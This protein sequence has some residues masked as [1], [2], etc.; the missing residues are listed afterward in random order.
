MYSVNFEPQRSFF[1]CINPWLRDSYMEEIQVVL[2]GTPSSGSAS[3]NTC[4]QIDL[5]YLKPSLDK[6][7]RLL[8]SIVPSRTTL[9]N[10]LSS[11]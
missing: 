5:D 9:W 8:T 7:I 3:E 1:T 2:K 6:S 4:V 11:T 10:I